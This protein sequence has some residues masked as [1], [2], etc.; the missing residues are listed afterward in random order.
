MDEFKNCKIE[1]DVDGDF[2]CSVLRKKVWINTYS[3]NEVEAFNKMFDLIKELNNLKINKI[4]KKLVYKPTNKEVEVKRVRQNGK[5]E[6]TNG[7][8]IPSIELELNYEFK[9]K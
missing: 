8:V 3:T 7:V 5:V 2:K 6:L 4:M 1:K 9:N